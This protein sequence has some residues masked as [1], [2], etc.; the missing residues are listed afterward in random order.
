MKKHVGSG[1]HVRAI[2]AERKEKKRR[3][4]GLT[5]S[6]QKCAK[7]VRPVGETLPLAQRLHRMSVVEHFL[8]A[9]IPL[10]KIDELRPL[11]EEKF[12]LTSSAHMSEYIPAILDE[13]RKL[14]A[15]ELRDQPISLIFDGTTRWGEAIAIVARFVSDDWKI[16]RR[17][18][19]LTTVAKAVTAPQPAQVIN[20]CVST[21]YQHPAELVVAA[22]RD[23]AS[24]NTTAVRSLSV[25][26]P[27]MVDVVCFS[28]TCA[29][30]DTC[31]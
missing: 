26:Y 19:Q 23:G 11:L 1:K 13:E 9:G 15:S 21:R 27:N 24:V 6:M 22:M 12:R 25:F 18:V 5:E 16:Q 2:E 10:T 28:H 30:T 4:Q 17:L 8:R 29:V 31:T 14:L 20:K 3:Q 7:D